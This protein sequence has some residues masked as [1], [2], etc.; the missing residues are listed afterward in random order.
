VSDNRQAGEIYSN[1]KRVTCSYDEELPTPIVTNPLP[2][3][4]T[5]SNEML[6][7]EDEA[8]EANY[9]AAA[10][11]RW[12]G[13]ERW[14][15]KENEEMRLVNIMHPHTIFRKLRRAGVDARIEAP[16]FYV[17]DIDPK[18]GAPI[19]VKQERTA[20][21]LW[22]HDDVIVGRVGISAWVWDRQQ[23]RRVRECVTSLQYPYGPEW[24]LMRFDEYDVPT[25]E[26]YRGWRTAMLALIR[27]GVLT[28][29]EVDRAFG[30]VVLNDAS[31]LYRQMLVTPRKRR[32]GLI[33]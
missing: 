12:K 15:G 26:R 1:L 16:S 2:Y 30:P 29:E 8:F 7:A 10:K 19:R 32:A 5:S 27:K 3:T 4:E 33:Q 24:S 21:R 11:Q 31:L 23:K 25:E 20:G 9:L 18:T 17:W 14:M 13:Q 22:L 28:E 6:D